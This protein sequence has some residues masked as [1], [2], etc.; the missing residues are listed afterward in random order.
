MKALIVSRLLTWQ[1]TWIDQDV[2][3]CSHTMLLTV[4]EQQQEALALEKAGRILCNVKL[5][6]AWRGWLAVVDQ[7]HYLQS[8]LGSALNLFVNRR[9]TLAWQAWKVNNRIRHMHG[10]TNLLASTAGKQY[11]ELGSALDLYAS[12]CLIHAWKAWKMNH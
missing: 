6:A 8:K 12:R 2:A 4:Q 10:I 9:L 7:R 3:A 5:A 11:A 1:T